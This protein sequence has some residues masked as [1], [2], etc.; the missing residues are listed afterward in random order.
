MGIKEQNCII[1]S[2]LSVESQLKYYMLAI[3]N[4]NL[5]EVNIYELTSDSITKHIKTGESFNRNTR[6]FIHRYFLCRSELYPDT[7]YSYYI[8]ALNNGDELTIPLVYQEEGKYFQKDE[9]QLLILGL[10]NGLFVMIFI[11]TTFLFISTLLIKFLPKKQEFD[12]IKYLRKIFNC[13]I[14][15][16]VKVVVPSIFSRV[17]NSTRYTPGINSCGICHLKQ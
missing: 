1:I 14:H 7:T 15:R 2:E 3:E 12:S 11:F 17:N 9:K 5:D 8:R 16:K 6:E 13:I 10:C 4:P